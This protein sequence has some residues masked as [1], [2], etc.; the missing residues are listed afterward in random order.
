MQVFFVKPDNLNDH[1]LPCC[2]KAGIAHTNFVMQ[3]QSVCEIPV[4]AFK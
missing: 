2:I 4:S 1:T 3:R